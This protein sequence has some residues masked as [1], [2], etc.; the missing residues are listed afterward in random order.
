MEEYECEYTYEDYL[1]EQAELDALEDFYECPYIPDDEELFS[2]EPDNERVSYLYR[3]GSPLPTAEELKHSRGT[4]IIPWNDPEDLT[5]E[6][7]VNLEVRDGIARIVI[8]EKSG[9]DEPF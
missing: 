7:Q 2:E 5:E 9:E 4:H 1:R 8:T 6:Y 3:Y